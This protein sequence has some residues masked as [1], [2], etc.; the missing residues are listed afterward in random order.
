MGSFWYIWNLLSAMSLS[1]S[2]TCPER[3]KVF[4]CGQNSP[5]AAREEEGQLARIRDW[6]Y[7]KELST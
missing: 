2:E 7:G 5:S 6:R 4:S 3:G 1:R